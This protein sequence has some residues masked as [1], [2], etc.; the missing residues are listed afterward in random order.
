MRQIKTLE[1]R[2]QVATVGMDQ[3][4]GRCGLRFLAACNA[5]AVGQQRW[6]T[7]QPRALLLRGRLALGLLA[8]WLRLFS[9][10]IGPIV[11]L[12]EERSDAFR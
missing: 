8:L 9:A 2:V 4:V 5:H 10:A 6:N 1:R 7:E 3:V 11:R 12:P